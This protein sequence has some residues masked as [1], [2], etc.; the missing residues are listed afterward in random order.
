MD[1][2]PI[3]A[4][5]RDTGL[6]FVRA[7]AIVLVVL[8]H[9]ASA[10]LS[11]AVGAFDW[12]CSLAWGSLARPSVP[13]FF[14]CTGALMLCRDSTTPRRIL[15]HNLPRILCAMFVWALAY[16]LYWL[17]ETNELTRATLWDSVKRTLLLQHEFHF[18]YLHV[19]LLVYAFL[20]AVRVFVRSASRREL[21]YLLGLWAVT[22]ILLPLLRNF[23]PFTLVYQIG[24][25]YMMNM[26]YSA[27]GYALLGHY[28]RRYGPSIRPG[29]FAVAY[30]SGLVF[31]FSGC[32]AMSL[33]DGAL[34][35]IFLEGMSPGPMLMAAGLF[36]LIIT[37][38]A[39][40]APVARL[41]GRLAR[42]SFCIY[43]V[44]VFFLRRLNLLGLS[45]GAS[46]CLL[47]IPLVCLLLLAAG[48][49]TW[50]GLRHIPIVRTYLI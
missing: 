34:N 28:L 3:Q 33:R 43:L 35:E 11:G 8:T 47:S 25:R 18:Y 49:L 16:R 46:P 9:C 1:N 24:A 30:L 15:I 4:P 39:W 42:A 21:E 40:P 5:G 14:M 19:L 29:W 27:I 31:T 38:K 17:W 7:L 10:G 26:A 44:H 45:A 13:L 2:R 37:R 41:T 36:G 12:W 22:G 50:E 48:W 32:A 6:D 23:W 20:P